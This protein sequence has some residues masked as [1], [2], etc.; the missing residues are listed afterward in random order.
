MIATD[1]EVV[2]MFGLE[3]CPWSKPGTN[4]YTYIAPR[5]RQR[6]K[7][8]PGPSTVQQQSQ[9]TITTLKDNRKASALRGSIDGAWPSSD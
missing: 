6:F 4:L 9:V 7:V 3:K 8:N 2:L 5:H 1:G